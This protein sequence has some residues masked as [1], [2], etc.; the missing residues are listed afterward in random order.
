MEERMPN[1]QE[2]NG[3]V[4]ANSP[5]FLHAHFVVGDW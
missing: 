1:E 5:D 2:P 4:Y 3:A